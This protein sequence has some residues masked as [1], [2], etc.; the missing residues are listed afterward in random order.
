MGFCVFFRNDAF[1]IGIIG[2]STFAKAFATL[3][4]IGS[5]RGAFANLSQPV[6]WLSRKHAVCALFIIEVL[7]VAEIKEV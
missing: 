6:L 4:L 5:F 7:E 3:Y 2:N 1:S